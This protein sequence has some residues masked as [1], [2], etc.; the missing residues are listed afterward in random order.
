M[1]NRRRMNRKKYDRFSNQYTH[2]W[3]S[4]ENNDYQML[5]FFPIAAGFNDLNQNY[6]NNPAPVDYVTPE[7]PNQQ[8]Y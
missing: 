2:C 5:D 1:S 3:L 6:F 7:S 4:F 8:N